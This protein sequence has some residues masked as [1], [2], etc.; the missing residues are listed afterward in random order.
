M[1]VF[2][3]LI[4]PRLNRVLV[5]RKL[6][7]L[8][9]F[10]FRIVTELPEVN[11]SLLTFLLFTIAQIRVNQETNLM[12]VD[13]L[14][15]VWGPNLLERPNAQPSVEDS[16]KCKKIVSCLLGQFTD[17]FCLQS[18]VFQQKLSSFFDTIWTEMNPGFEDRPPPEG[19]SIL[20]LPEALTDRG[21]S[22][23]YTT[24]G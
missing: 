1:A 24:S 20:H 12:S 13:A 2:H 19:I 8:N 10:Y 4:N 22:G 7:Y 16:A 9:I 6:K 14:S 15:T 21:F 17:I 5:L 18:V 11:Q 23:S 3:K